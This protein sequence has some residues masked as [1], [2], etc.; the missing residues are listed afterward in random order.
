MTQEY[1]HDI[2]NDTSVINDITFNITH[3]NVL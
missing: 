3:T 1:F 2:N